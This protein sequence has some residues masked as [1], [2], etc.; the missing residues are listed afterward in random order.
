MT[1]EGP[2]FGRGRRLAEYAALWGLIG[3]GG[4]GVE[5]TLR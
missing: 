4:S 1:G 3:F 5:F 2:R